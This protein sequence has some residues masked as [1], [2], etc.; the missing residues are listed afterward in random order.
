MMPLDPAVEQTDPVAA[1]TSRT[2]VNVTVGEAYLSLLAA[3]GIDYLF[4]NAGTDFAPLIEGFAKAQSTGI[5]MPTPITVPH[6][7]VAVAMSMGH[8]LV[9]GKPQAVMVHVN[10]GTANAICGVLNASRLRVPMLFTA[11]RTPI[12]ESG[13]AGARSGF[14]HW[15]QEMYDQAGMVREAVKWDYELRSPLQLEAVVDRALSVAANAPGG[16][17]YLTLPREVL[18]T[19][20]EKFTFRT[21][22]R[23]VCSAPV[24]ANPAAI[25]ATA[26]LLANAERPLIITSALGRT[27]SAVAALASLAEE[28]AL[29]VVLS[30]PRFMELTSEHPMHMGFDVAPWLKQADLVLVV[31]STAPWIPDQVTPRSDAK[32]IHLGEAPLYEELPMRSFACDLAITTEPSIG[33]K[34]LADALRALSDDAMRGAIAR[35]RATA[36][37][38]RQTWNAATEAALRETRAAPAITSTLVSRV[39]DEMRDPGSIVF[40]ESPLKLEQMRFTQPGTLFFAGAAGGLGWSLGAALGAQM[41][42]PAREV[43]VTVGDGA[44]MF[45]SPLAAHYVAAEHKLPV[46]F[47]VFNNRGWH[48]VRRATRGMY[49]DGFAARAAV[50]PLTQFGPDMHFEKAVEVAGGY[51]ERVEAPAQ[52][53]AAL[54]RC[55]DVIRCER[56]QAL[57]NVVC[58]PG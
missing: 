37:S 8:T 36:Q 28:F 19:P 52:L 10:V 49:R 51:G 30:N 20:L 1:A 58:L 18:A 42:A 26:R 55:F 11:G 43:I 5:A 35:R 7:N 46:L 23:Q 40:K 21:K 3:R 12:L 34:A 13:A 4:A 2:L 48:A 15:P 41:A 57:L 22:P 25:D 31:E 44:Y 27:P 39:L 50:E 9:S 47:V 56:R 16:P 33:L 38:A 17:V 45:G 24:A 32:I 29:P 14:I 6:E 53:A 54:G